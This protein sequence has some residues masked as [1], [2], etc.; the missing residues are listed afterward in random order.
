[1]S[2]M[3]LSSFRL[4]RA[5]FFSSRSSSLWQ[6]RLYVQ[7]PRSPAQ[8]N[9]Q[10]HNWFIRQA[11]ENRSP[12]ASAAQKRSA[13]RKN[14]NFSASL[15]SVR[16]TTMAGRVHARPPGQKNF[17]HVFVCLF[18]SPRNEK[19]WGSQC[20]DVAAALPYLLFSLV[21]QTVPIRSGEKQRHRHEAT[22]MLSHICVRWTEN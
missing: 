17:L 1:M 11:V 12:P 7:E 3:R 8:D 6:L 22:A 19:P 18:A 9:R 16:N 5:C 14:I 20:W 4:G 10:P 13:R 2:E 15:I 21:H